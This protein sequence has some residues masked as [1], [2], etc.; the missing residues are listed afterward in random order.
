MRKLIFLFLL[1]ACSQKQPTAPLLPK[2]KVEEIKKEIIPIA[3]R[4]IGHFTAY[5]SAEIKAQVEGELLF[6]HFKEG[7]IVN[8]SDLLFTI[9]PRVYQTAVDQAKATLEETKVNLSY[10]TE[11]VN[12]YERLLPKQYVSELNFLEFQTRKQAYEAELLKNEALLKKAEI[13]LDYCFIKAPF[14]GI[15]SKQL[16]DIGNLIVNNGEPLIIIKQIDPIYVDFSIPER[17]FLRLMRFQ[18]AGERVIKVT[19]PDRPDAIFLGKLVLVENQI[20]QKTGMIPLRGELENSSNIFWPGQF[21]RIEVILQEEEALLIPEEAVNIGQKGQYAFV[22]N[23]ENIAEYR[24]LELGEQI[25][26]FVEVKSGVSIG[27]KV[28]TQ[29]QLNVRPNHAVRL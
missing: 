1:V 26:N 5:N 9:D 23:Q 25:G 2:V 13:N 21:V 17:D 14:T 27:E 28:V 15:T 12:M 7:S 8:K 4:G 19:F 20:D 10:A 29:G 16:I 22:I 6:V 18:S 3:I 11:K 24:P